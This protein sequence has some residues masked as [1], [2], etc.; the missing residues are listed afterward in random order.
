MATKKKTKKKKAAKQ[1][2][3]EMRLIAP[4]IAQCEAKVPN[5]VTAF[6][7]GGA[8]GR[9]RCPN[10]PMVILTEN[11]PGSDGLHGSMTVCEQCLDVFKLQSPR[12]KVTIWRKELI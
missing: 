9:V 10:K 8:P 7:L 2:P 6:T 11:K 3:K 5:G 4:D 12:A 1:R